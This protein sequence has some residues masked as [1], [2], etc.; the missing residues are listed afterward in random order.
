ML[1]Y[2]IVLSFVFGLLAGVFIW[3]ILGME[4]NNRFGEKLRGIRL[5]GDTVYV[6]NLGSFVAGVFT[7]SE[8]AKE[9]INCLGIPNNEAI[10]QVRY[11][12]MGEDLKRRLFNLI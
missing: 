2:S 6:I 3:G 10:T 4:V 1:T 8:K 12:D 7:T 5:S 9:F 11:L